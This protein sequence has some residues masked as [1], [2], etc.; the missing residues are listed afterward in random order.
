[1]ISVFGRLARFVKEELLTQQ[2]TRTELEAL[3]QEKGKAKDHYTF[4]M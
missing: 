2:I 3:F 4:W 1:M